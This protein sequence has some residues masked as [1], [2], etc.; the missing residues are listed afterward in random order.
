MNHI[1]IRTC[2]IQ[3]IS[4]LDALTNEQYGIIVLFLLIA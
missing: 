4:Q 1:V 3:V 2:N